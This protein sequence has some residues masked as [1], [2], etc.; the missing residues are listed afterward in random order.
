MGFDG[1]MLAVCSELSLYNKP[2][3]YKKK[4]ALKRQ[5]YCFEQHN[6]FKT[7]TPHI[8]S[9][10]K[11]RPSSIVVVCSLFTGEYNLVQTKVFTCCVDTITFTKHTQSLS[12]F[13]LHKPSACFCLSCSPHAV[14][15]SLCAIFLIC[16]R[17]F[18]MLRRREGG[19]Q[20]TL[21]DQPKSVAS[22]LLTVLLH[23]CH[24]FTIRQLHVR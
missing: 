5:E 11:N 7:C 17:T 18:V 15:L 9:Q 20:L 2:W 19:C 8:C 3:K 13:F 24:T 4:K 6:T 14:L 23:E 12:P 22:Y 16:V 10:W 1:P 21:G